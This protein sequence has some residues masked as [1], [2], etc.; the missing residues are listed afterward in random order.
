MFRDFFNR[1]SSYIDPSPTEVPPKRNILVIHCHP[2]EDSFS[3]ALLS[4]VTSGLQSSGQNVRVR[5][6][7]PHQQKIEE[8]YSNDE[9]GIFAPQLTREE[10]IEYFNG[11]LIV[12]YISYNA[13]RS[14]ILMNTYFLDAMHTW[15]L[16]LIHTYYCLHL[17][18]RLTESN[19]SSEI[20]KAVADLRWA[21]SLVFV[22]PTWW[23]N[24]PA[25]L[26]GYFDRVFLPVQE[27][28]IFIYVCMYVMYVC[29]HVVQ[30]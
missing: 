9:T 16:A 14:Y 13:S 27:K 23:F 18:S 28:K 11:K 17:A 29:M 19:K 6:L 25:A 20:T 24:F 5:R 10:R 22:Y 7:Y 3:N 21:N 15:I 26:K 4:A 1:I 30:I 2:V 8:S 12:Y